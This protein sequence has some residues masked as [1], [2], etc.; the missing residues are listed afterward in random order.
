MSRS[1][2]EP[3]G[4]PGVPPG[5][6][7]LCTRLR[8]QRG[9]RLGQQQR[10][11]LLYPTLLPPPTEKVMSCWL[12]RKGPAPPEISHSPR[13]PVSAGEDG[14]HVSPPQHLRGPTPAGDGWALEHGRILCQRQEQ[15]LRNSHGY[16]LREH[17]FSIAR[18]KALPMS[19]EMIIRP[20]PCF[21]EP[22]TLGQAA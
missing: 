19:T 3:P 14:R 4:S 22:R 9:C 15:P 1:S 16:S 20:G 18:C 2:W 8:L 13:T 11:Q 6:A 21:Q 5:D 10:Q 7:C 17:S 12:S